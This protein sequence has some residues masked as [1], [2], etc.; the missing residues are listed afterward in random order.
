MIPP[1]LPR[2]E[3]EQQL[4]EKGKELTAKLKQMKAEGRLIQRRVSAGPAVPTKKVVFHLVPVS[5]ELNL[6]V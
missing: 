6:E 2:N 3:L 5:L 1:P 4:A